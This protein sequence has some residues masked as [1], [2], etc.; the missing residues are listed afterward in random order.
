[1]SVIP[2]DVP[3]DCVGKILTR[4][5]KLCGSGFVVKSP[6]Y[7][8]T[9]AHVVTGANNAPLFYRPACTVG[10]GSTPDYSLT[11]ECTLDRYDL[12]VFRAD[13]PTCGG[14]I[15]L[16]RFASVRVTSIKF[17]KFWFDESG[18]PMASPT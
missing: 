2:R 11:V 16:G 13:A 18:E 8:V 9:A 17:C 12:A 3:A 6:K 15:H 7:V 4:T 10:G 14:V 5:G 1:M